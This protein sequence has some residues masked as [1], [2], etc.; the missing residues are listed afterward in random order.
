MSQADH[1]PRDDRYHT[2]QAIGKA[3]LDEER[4]RI[5]GLLAQQPA[6]VAALRAYTSIKESRLVHHLHLLEDRG[7]ITQRA[8]GDAATY[9]LNVTALHQWKRRLFAP[10]PVPQPPTPQQSVLARF[11]RRDQLIQ[12]PVQP[13]K[14]QLVL[15]WL[16]AQFE[17]G[18]AYL[19]R[20]VNQ[21]LQGH[22]VDHATLRR[23]LVDYG[24]LHRHA[25]IY[26]RVDAGAADDATIAE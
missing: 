9:C 10:D 4:L 12:L 8:E 17:V 3:L 16:A 21:R 1:V 24:W 7:F 15:A 5:V 11:V 13:A 2:L 23:L 18:V 26:Q 25:G 20:E 6:T 22:L 14:L 19:E